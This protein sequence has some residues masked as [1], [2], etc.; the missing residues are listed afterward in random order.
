L[1]TSIM[2]VFRFG[3]RN[4]RRP[5]TSV[6]LR[7]VRLLRQLGNEPQLATFFVV[8]LRVAAYRTLPASPWDGYRR[9]YPAG[10]KRQTAQPLS[11]TG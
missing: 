10:Q 9:R 2:P 8:L 7:T 11:R 3:D 1:I 5:E 6:N 4:A